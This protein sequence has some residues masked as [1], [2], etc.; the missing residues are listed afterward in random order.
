MSVK[1]TALG[2]FPE[3]ERNGALSMA[4]M[5]M[6]RLWIH[7]NRMLAILLRLKLIK[8]ETFAKGIIASRKRLKELKTQRMSKY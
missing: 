7:T 8:L 1:V 2:S 5:T 3:H 6:K 4:S